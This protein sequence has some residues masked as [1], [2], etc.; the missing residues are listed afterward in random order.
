MREGGCTSLIPDSATGRTGGNRTPNPRFWRP[1]LCQLSYCPSLALGAAATRRFPPAPRFAHSA[2]LALRCS[3]RLV[4]FNQ[5]SNPQSAVDNPSIGIRQ[6]AIANR[7]LGLP[8]RCV[9]TAEA[10]VLA[11]LEPLGRF[12]LVLGRAVVTPFAVLARQGNDVS[13]CCDLSRYVVRGAR[14]GF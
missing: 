11:E 3:L 12:L 5:Q 6:S 13:H 1:V 9:L 10:A 8:M 7:L 4:R 14:C 2:T